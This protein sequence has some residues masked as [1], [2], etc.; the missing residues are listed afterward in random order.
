MHPRADADELRQL[1]DVGLPEAGRDALGVLDD[2]IAA[3]EPGLVGNTDPHFFAWVMGAS[4]PAGVAADWLTSIWGQNAGIFQTSPAA[5]IAEEVT[6]KW[7]LELLD[8]PRGR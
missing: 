6:A 1:F 5:A 3:A 7:L 2:L 8:L 4:H